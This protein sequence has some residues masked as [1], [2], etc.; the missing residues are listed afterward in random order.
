MLGDG[1]TQYD[2]AGD[3]AKH[4]LGACSENFRRRNVNT[5][6]RV[7]YVKGSGLQLQLHL[8]EWDEWQTCFEVDINLPDNPYI[9]FTA[10]TGDVS[11]NHD[12]VSVQTYSATL[13]PQYRA[14]GVYSAASDYMQK[15][16]NVPNDKKAGA[17]GQAARDNARKRQSGGSGGGVVG[18]F[19]FL[20]KVSEGCCGGRSRCAD[21]VCS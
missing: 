3:N 16:L 1:K 21:A 15:P 4:E 7:T 14:Q 8:K 6:A 20:L 11:D 10:A 2:S 5:K 17:R 19:L 12:I 13:Y 9:G 18:W